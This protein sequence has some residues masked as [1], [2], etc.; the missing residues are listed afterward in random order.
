MGI[1]ISIL[2]GFI[3]GCIICCTVM[4]AI[5]LISIERSQSE[6]TNTLKEILKVLK[7]EES[8][9]VDKSCVKK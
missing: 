6:I 9:E 3:C 2:G 1:P 8:K 7:R 5:I 4:I